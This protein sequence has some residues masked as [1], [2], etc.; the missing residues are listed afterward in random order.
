[1]VTLAAGKVWIRRPP[2]GGWVD[3]WL[4]LTALGWAKSLWS[5]T[6]AEARTVALAEAMLAPRMAMSV[7]MGLSRW[8]LTTVRVR[9]LP[10]PVVAMEA[11]PLRPARVLTASREPV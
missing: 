1:M 5:W 7:V 2:A 10:L 11:D 3:A 8:G 6:S 4:G 9:S